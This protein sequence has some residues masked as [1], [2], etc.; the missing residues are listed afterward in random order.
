VPTDAADAPGNSA[1]HRLTSRRISVCGPAQAWFVPTIRIMAA[2]L[3]GRADFTLDGIDDLRMAVDEA[4]GCLLLL[5]DQEQPLHCSFQVSPAKIECMSG[6]PSDTPI[7]PSTRVG[8]VGG[9]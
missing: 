8:S 2:D 7:P 4:C 6:C 1:P 9:S 3:A 5:A